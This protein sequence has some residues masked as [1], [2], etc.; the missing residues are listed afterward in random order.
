M[1]LLIKEGRQL[2]DPLIES[3]DTGRKYSAEELSF[4]ELDDWRYD[5]F[6]QILGQRYKE[7][8]Q[9]WLNKEELVKLMDWK[10]MKGK[11][12]P[13]LP[14]LI[15]SNDEKTVEQVTKSGFGIFIESEEEYKIRLKKLLNK[16]CELR[17]VGPATSTLMISLLSEIKG[18]KPLP[19]FSDESFYWFNPKYGKLK[20]TLKEYLELYLDKYLAIPKAN[21]F[22]AIERATWAIYKKHE[23]DP[24]F[25]VDPAYIQDYDTYVRHL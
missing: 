21:D 16:L 4:K 9:V 19:F 25:K 10:L 22:N 13:T 8:G 17:G 18:V 12:R 14:K 2:Y 20:Y 1:D 24:M 15:K 23:V 3:L 7:S 6:P 5:T 11:F